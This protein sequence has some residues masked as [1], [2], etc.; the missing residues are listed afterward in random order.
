MRS[1][2]HIAQINVG[3]TLYPTDDVRMSGFM[4]RLDDINTLADR[5]P[6]FVWRLQSESGNATDIDVGGP[7]LFLVNMSVWTSVE[8]LFEFVYKTAH[9]PV[10]IDRRKWFQ[11]PDGAYQALWWVAAGHLPAVEEGLARLELLNSIGPSP[12]AFSFNSKYPPPDFEGGP[13]DL[14]PEPYC[15]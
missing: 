5:S 9:R 2:W 10:M 12:R 8:A 3:T 1:N 14:E 4:S 11:K 7:P 15:S 6:G 13:K